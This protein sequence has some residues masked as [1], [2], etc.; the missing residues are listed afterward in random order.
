MINH[1]AVLKINVGR[2]QNK[3]RPCSKWS[4]AVLKINRVVLKNKQYQRTHFII[5]HTP[6]VEK[7]EHRWLCSK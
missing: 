7:N 5:G 6:K 4:M 3:R 2:A 1:G